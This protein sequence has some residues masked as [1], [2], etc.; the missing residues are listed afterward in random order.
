MGLMALACL[1]FGGLARAQGTYYDAPSTSVPTPPFATYVHDTRLWIPNDVTVIRGVIVIGNGAG[2]DQRGQTAESDWQAL[3]RAHGFA[4]MGTHGYI[5]YHSDA[6]V[7]AEVPVLLG[8]LAWYATASGHPEVANLPFVLAGWS[9]GGQIAYGINTN[10]PERV[11]AFIVNKG[12]NY[13]PEPP[14][15]AAL[16]TPSIFVGGQFDVGV[17]RTGI[18]DRFEANRPR[19]AL[20]ALAF[21]HNTGHA[22]GNVDGMFFTLFDHAIRARYPAGATPLNGP[23]TLL[24]LPE[25]SGWLATKPTVAN[26]L[27]GK[28]Y[29]YAD[30][31]GDRTTACWLMD[32]GVANLY[33]GFATYNPAVT[34]TVV[35]G[36]VFAAGQT[37]QFEVSVDSALFPGWVSADL[38]DGAVKLGTVTHGG[39]NTISAVRPWGGRGVT[40]IARDAAGNER[41][42]I[43]RS[44]VVSNAVALTNNAT[45]TVGRTSADLSAT[46]CPAWGSYTVTAYWGTVNGGSN[47]ANWQHSAVV[48]TWTGGDATTISYTATGLSEVTPYYF[49]FRASKTGSQVWAPNVLS[50]TT[51]TPNAPTSSGAALTGLEDTD[52]ALAAG[53]FGYTDPLNVAL[54]AVQITSLPALGTLKNGGVTVVN[55]DLPLT[56]LAA[57]IGNLI[58]QSASNG[59]GTPYTT[60]GI[61]V[62]NAGDLW[63]AGAPMTLNVTPVNDAPSSTGGSANLATGTD[64]TFAAGD[65][66]F[67]DVDAGDTLSAIKITMLPVHGTLNLNGTPITSV[68]SAAIPV[69]NIGT[70]VYTPAANYSGADSFKYQV[71]DATVFSADAT[72]AI[73]VNYAEY[74]T[75]QNGSFEIT[76]PGDQTWSD[77]NWAFIP[78]PWT[79]NLTNYGR[80]K[81]SSAPVGLPALTG[82]GTWMA[83]MMNS[84]NWVNQSLGSQSFSAGDTL[85][86]TFYLCRD[87]TGSGILQASFIVGATTYSQT[88]DLTSQTVNTWQ[89]YTLTKT[90]P[91]AVTANLSLKFSNVSGKGW[92]D[93]ISNVSV[94]AAPVSASF[95]GWA[96]ASGAGGQTMEQ[97]HDKDGV[98]NGIEYFLRGN[99]NTT[100]FTPLPGV[101][102]SAGGL[103]V[104]WTKASDYAGVYGTDYAV[105]TTSTLTGTWTNEPAPGNVILSGNDVI[106][107]FPSPITGQKFCRLKVMGPP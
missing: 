106:Y 2:G 25:T 9:G 40:A 4:L 5:C 81:Y 52:T 11:I 63:S 48:G 92:L 50:F 62:M 32:E 38:Y 17:G 8:D 65:F 12:A 30:Y 41:T 45:T 35:G 19:G 26:G 64:K 66:Q 70:L 79:T 55:G 3:A 74:I 82:G 107:T 89:S 22:E 28:V 83:N 18:M 31:T 24:D 78:S 57:N 88:F 46:F 90:I 33:R 14:S 104:T 58:Y 86:V 49:T 80:L 99:A 59:N 76:N 101:V 77:G 1:V 47:A 10:M 60:M 27:S 100:G 103:S 68:P 96:A 13:V 71:K 102:K 73:S 97:D 87:S 39:S 85:S 6:V 72:M 53:N 43:P 34:V 54:A 93:K 61:K 51:V 98:P 84:A 94:T 23:V 16:K 21:E 67:A 56:V 37:I 95:A 15:A 29:P 105:Q 36:P 7:N 69:A 42:S 20:W 91:T 75:V 44:F